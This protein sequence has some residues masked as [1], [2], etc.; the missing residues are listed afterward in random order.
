MRIGIEGIRLNGQ[1][2]M[3]LLLCLVENQL[4]SY[5]EEN[6]P[7]TKIGQKYHPTSK[8][9]LQQEIEKKNYPENTRKIPPK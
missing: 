5:R 2:M 1:S 8:F 7:K 4:V 3:H 9:P 6:L